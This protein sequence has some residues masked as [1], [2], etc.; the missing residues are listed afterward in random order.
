VRGAMKN[1]TVVLACGV[2]TGACQYLQQ[3]ETPPEKG[4][5]WSTAYGGNGPLPGSIPQC[6]TDFECSAGQ[7]CFN[8]RCVDEGF[9]GGSNFGGSTG[10]DGGAVVDCV[11]TGGMRSGLLRSYAVPSGETKVRCGQELQSFELSTL[12][13]VA[14]GFG[15]YYGALYSEDFGSAAACGAC[16]EIVRDGATPLGATIVDECEAPD[17]GPGDLSL[18]AQALLDL[19]V[20]GELPTVN[21]RFVECPTFEVVSFR[22]E[23]PL[24]AQGA[25]QVQGH[26]FALTGLEANVAG[27]WQPATRR[28]DNYWLLPLGALSNSVYEVRVTDINGSA[29]GMTLALTPDEQYSGLQFPTCM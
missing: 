17:C 27:M 6:S 8:R 12:T 4:A 25:V 2:L 14:T 16:V 21:W 9:G 3:E 5:P 23:D 11:D 13:H 28:E 22:L 18:S 29:L 19:G 10:F 24:A 1:Y 20:A 7:I 15:Q 26:R